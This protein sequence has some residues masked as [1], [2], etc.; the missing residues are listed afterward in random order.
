MRPRESEVEWTKQ[1]TK[2]AGSFLVRGQLGSPDATFLEQLRH[3]WQRCL[4]LIPISSE[5]KYG[6][7][8]HEA[9]KMD[10]RKIEGIENANIQFEPRFPIELYSFFHSNRTRS[11]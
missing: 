9:S 7:V 1:R 4:P 2:P 10:C 3:S 6:H 5:K 8:S 11:L